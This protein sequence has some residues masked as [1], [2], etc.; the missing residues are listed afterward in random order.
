MGILMVIERVNL[1]V[2]KKVNR[3]VLMKEHVMAWMLVVMMECLTDA[4]L[5]KYLEM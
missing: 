5:V 1:T 4:L 3:R 2:A